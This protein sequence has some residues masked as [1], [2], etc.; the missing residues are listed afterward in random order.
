MGVRV[1]RKQR[2]SHHVGSKNHSI[3][4]LMLQHFEE[5]NDIT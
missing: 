2:E 4:A 5:S 1:D 3:K